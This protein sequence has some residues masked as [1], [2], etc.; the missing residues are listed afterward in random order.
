MTIQSLL[1]DTIPRNTSLLS[2]T[3]K[4]PSSLDELV[5]LVETYDWTDHSVR[6]KFQQDVLNSTMRSR[7]YWLHQPYV[8]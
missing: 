7:C 4:D 6:S 8:C 1:Y 3:W 5:N 2:Y